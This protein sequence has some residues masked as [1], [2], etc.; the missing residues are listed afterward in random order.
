MRPAPAVL[1]RALLLALAVLCPP[2]ARAQATGSIAGRVFDAESGQPIAGVSVAVVWPAPEGGGE[3]RQELRTSDAKGAFEFPAIPA[4]TYTIGFTKAG[5]RASDMRGLEVVAGRASRADFPMPKLPAA[6]ADSVLELDAFVVEASTVEDDL[7]LLELRMDADQLLNTMSADDLSRFAA[8]DVGDALKRVAGVNVVG[9]Q[10]AVIRGLD[11]RYNST[12]FNGAPI[13]SPDPDRQS[14]QLDLFPSDIVSNLIVAK[15]FGPGLPSNSSGGSIDIVTQAYPDEFEIKLSGGSGFS[16]NAI[17]RFWRYDDG[18]PVGTEVDGWDAVENEFGASIGG[19][20]ELFGREIRLKGLIARELDFD[21]AEGFQEDREPRL[22]QFRRLPRPGRFVRSGDL[23]LGELGLSDGRFDLTESERSEQ[24]TG[25]LGLGFDLDEAGRH[26][27]DAT[28]LYTWRQ[29]EI[30]QIAENGT[31]PGFDYG[32]LA[33]QDATFGAIDT[34]AFDG[35]ATLGSWIARSLRESRDDPATRGPL[36]FTTF[37]ENESFRRERDLQ[38][39]QVNGDHRFELL[40]GLR[41]DWAAN[42]A[43]TT[44]EESA[45]GARM[46]FE[47]DDPSATPPAVPAAVDELGPGSWAVNSGIFFS[48]N[49]IDETQDFGRFDLEYEY[50]FLDDALLLKVGGGGWFESA[51]RSVSSS[52]LESPTVGGS[53]QFVLFGD[54][55]EAL[56]DSIL[57]SLDRSG[58]VL[59]GLRE[60]ASEATRDVTAWNVEAKATLWDRLDLLGGLRIEHVEIESRNEAFTGEDRFGAPAI[61][62][63]AYLFFDRLDNPARGEVLAPPPP[64]TAFNDELLGVDVP[65]DSASGFVDL[66]DRASIES[67]INGRIDERLTLPSAGFA[68]RPIAG[69][70]LRGA[71]S[72]TVARPSFRELGYYVSV[73]PGSDDLVVGNPQLQLSDVTSWDLRAEYAWGS[74][75]DLVAVSLFRKRIE[76]PIESIVVRNPLNAE[77]SSSALYRTFFNNPNEGD[78]QGIEVEARKAL[79]FLGVELLEHFSI[80]GNFTWIDAKV[81]RTEAELARSRPFTGVAPGDPGR[82]SG[83]EKSR[84][85]FGQPEWIANADLT[86]EHPDW[87]T[88][89]T[90]AWFAIS[91]VLDAA[92]SASIGPDGSVL[93]ATLDRYVDSYHQLDLVMSQTWR[94]ERLDSEL[95]AK[96]SVKNLTNTTR[97][98]VYDPYQTHDEISERAFELGRDFSFSLSWRF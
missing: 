40:E 97:R 91:D 53:S 36:W 26:Q 28:G 19:R 51:E 78:L 30:V 87:G 1:L 18:S 50:G 48:A 63:E 90:L 64:G 6:T 96:L 3:R 4:G 89:I 70:A 86:F 35:F 60:T 45:V 49:D 93:S 94:I 46:F 22:A 33:A 95:T 8:S 68:I 62:P 13:P 79:D 80:G 83:L 59:S 73:E 10:F 88:K 65:I 24:R 37:A 69:L 14:V 47:P 77:G 39:H 20:R 52:F 29:E 21:T 17:D 27:I 31:I 12:L 76:D 56:G 42:H 16:T 23:S 74:A 5:Y 75:G 7:A 38:V 15:T 34:A 9:G 84:R 43:K 25:Y 58:G 54:S 81:D 55:Q 61:F 2:P 32:L 82:F 71:W 57:G 41:L 11:D 67:L 44:Q 92:G 98:I 72:K 66:L 85:L